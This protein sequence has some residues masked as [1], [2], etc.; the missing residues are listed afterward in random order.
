M[1]PGPR[2][3]SV[4]ASPARHR[5]RHAVLLTDAAGTLE[6]PQR[7]AV[8]AA[9]DEQAQDVL[10]EVEEHLRIALRDRCVQRRQRERALLGPGP[11][12]VASGCG[13]H[14]REPLPDGVSREDLLDA[15]RAAASAYV[16]AAGR[17]VLDWHLLVL[18]AGP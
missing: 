13:A 17:V 7:G 8:V 1:F 6:Q 15:L 14:R 12:Q 9:I 4:A 18:T 2:L 16:D 5:P 3:V 11:T 10:D